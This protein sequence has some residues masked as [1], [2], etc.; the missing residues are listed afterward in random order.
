MNTSKRLVLGTV[1][2]GLPYGINNQ[3]GLLPEAEV[4]EILNRAAIMGIETLDTAAAYGEAERRI[5]SYHQ[6]HDKGFKIISKFSKNSEDN[7]A[8]SLNRSLGKLKLERLETIMFHSF[9][10][11]QENKDNLKD[12]INTKDKLYK[13]LGV[14]VYTNREVMALKDED[15][16]DVIQLPFNMLDNEQQRGQKLRELKETG[17]EIHTRSCF[18]QGLFFMDEK[19]LP[20]NLK[21]LKPYL[22]QIKNLA[23]DYNLEKGHL[24][25]QYVVNKEY[26]DAVL[27]G[28]DSVKQLEQNIYWAENMIPEAILNEIDNIK[29]KDPF[30]LNPSE[31]QI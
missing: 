4:Y 24:A 19:N 15:E 2:F 13:K 11:Y 6:K 22:E 30:L 9:D 12:I 14:S 25:M 3:T 5:G 8:L 18:L 29:V 21:P 7:W 20:G 16:V 10:A 23:L 26:V 28:V 17:K 1:Q 31:W 27:F